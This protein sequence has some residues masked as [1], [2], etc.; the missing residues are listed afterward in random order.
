M[1]VLFLLFLIYL[2]K[3]ISYLEEFSEPAKKHYTC[4]ESFHQSFGNID[5]IQTQLYAEL[6]HQN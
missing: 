4:K 5:L 2:L 6:N 3:K 1:I